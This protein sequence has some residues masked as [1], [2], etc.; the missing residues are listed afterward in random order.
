MS[1][2][3]LIFL[4]IFC[5][6]IGFNKFKRVAGPFSREQFLLSP[7]WGKQSILGT[8]INSYALFANLFSVSFSEIVPDYKHFKVGKSDNFRYLTKILMS[9]MKETGHFGPP[10]VARRVLWNSLSVPLLLPSV[11]VFSWNCIINFCK[12]LTF[13]Y[14][15]IWSYAWQSQI[16]WENFYCPQN[17]ENGSKVGF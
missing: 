5:I 3:W 9:K 10:M 8:K 15:P 16:F 4:L 12:I 1:Q 7:K 11:R 17:W 6:V 14:K 13:C 2:D